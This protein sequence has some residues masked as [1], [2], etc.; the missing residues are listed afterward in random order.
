MTFSR[1]PGSDIVEKPARIVAVPSPNTRG[2]VVALQSRAFSDK[3][4]Q[5]NVPKWI[6]SIKRSLSIGLEQLRFVESNR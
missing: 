6:G 2:N 4:S 3:F 1:M 5:A